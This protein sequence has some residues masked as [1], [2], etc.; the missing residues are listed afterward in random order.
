MFKESL[1]IVK[2]QS[3]LVTINEFKMVIA[4]KGIEYAVKHY[5]SPS[6]IKDNDLRRLV[7]DAESAIAKLEEYIEEHTNK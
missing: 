4:N 5:T 2:P 6:K 3:D 7:V 1:T